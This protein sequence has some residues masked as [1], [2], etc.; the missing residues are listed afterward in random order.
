M[1]VT[2]GS[3]SSSTYSSS[4]LHSFHSSGHPVV[5]C[6]TCREVATDTC[7][8]AGKH[9]KHKLS[10]LQNAAVSQT[11][12]LTRDLKHLRNT[13]KN[14]GNI[15]Q[16][17][18]GAKKQCKDVYESVKE[19]IDGQYQELWA[20]LEQNRG[21]ALNLL[22]VERETLQK[23]LSQLE[24]HQK[25][26]T[27]VQ[28]KIQELEN[29]QTTDPQALLDEI[30]KQQ[31]CLDIMEKFFSAVNKEIKCG[32]SAE[33]MF[34]GV[35][36]RALEESVKNIV[37]K[38]Q[39]LLPQP[40]DF[41]EAVTFDKRRMHKDLRISEERMQLI[42]RGCPSNQTN[43]HTATW[44]SAV[45][46]QSFSE[47]QHYWEVD[48]GGSRSWAVGVVEQGW[49][50]NGLDRPLGRDRT[51]WVLESDEGDLVALHSDVFS[52]VGSC[53]VRRLGVCVDCDKG[54]VKFCDVN[55]A[56]LLHI[57]FTRFSSSVHPAFSLRHTGRKRSSN[58][59]IC[60]LFPRSENAYLEEEEEEEDENSSRV[61]LRT[62]TEG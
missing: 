23:S 37:Q 18:T 44:C 27:Q 46:G 57:F 4:S 1:S 10:E 48:V 35:R 30:K 20:L 50:E 32:D 40:W 24:E 54:K 52:A 41:S 26:L 47:G 33:G 13:V 16:R 55:S 56:K 8:A 17:S 43:K 19:Y 25:T 7:L 11:E 34:N 60:K 45:A 31:E 59:T 53:S 12:R 29:Q 36:L 3:S 42:L 21:Q 14:C 5:F 58:L 2:S 22:E 6:E 61:N 38:N 62:S 51:S 15:K 49:E 28:E 9:R 39:E